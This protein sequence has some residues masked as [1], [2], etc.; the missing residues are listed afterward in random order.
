MRELLPPAFQVHGPEDLLDRSELNSH[1]E[2]EVPPGVRISTL[3]GT[4]PGEPDSLA[5]QAERQQLRLD[6]NTFLLKRAAKLRGFRFTVDSIAEELNDDNLIIAQDVMDEIQNLRNSFAQNV[7]PWTTMQHL[8]SLAAGHILQRSWEQ[9]GASSVLG[10]GGVKAD[11]E[12]MVIKWTDLAAASAEEEAA[13][14]RLV[15][16]KSQWASQ[17]V[18]AAHIHP[19]RR[20]GSSSPTSSE[21]AASHIDPI[22]QQVKADQS[23]D[24]HERALLGCIVDPAAVNKT[25]FDDVALDEKIKDTVRTAISLPL[26]YPEAFTTGILGQQS[27]QGVLLYGPPGTGKTHL[28]RALANESG[29]RMIAVTPGDINDM[30]VGQSEA[31]VKALFSLARKL[32]PSIVFIDEAES[33]LS[34]RGSSMSKSAAHQSTLTEF[35]QEMDGL[36]SAKDNTDTRVSVVAATNRPFDMDEAVLRRLPRRVLVDLPTAE[37]REAILGI[38]LKGEKLGEDVDLKQL[39]KETEA[40]SGSDLRHLCVTAAMDAIKELTPPPWKTREK[41]AAA[42]KN[43]QEDRGES[44]SSAAGGSSP[45]SKQVLRHR[46]HEDAKQQ[47]AVKRV[48]TSTAAAD[49]VSSS[50]QDTVS[51]M[52]QSPSPPGR[53]MQQRPSGLALHLAGGHH[54]SAVNHEHSLREP[55]QKDHAVSTRG[56]SGG[57][58]RATS[59]ESTKDTTSAASRGAKPTLPTRVLY[60]RHFDGAL[61]TIT[62]SSAVGTIFYIQNANVVY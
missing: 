37:N 33:L 61:K 51:M 18:Q 25:S 10:G 39:A 44:S 4:I 8:V 55:M 34:S 7:W 45:S 36:T 23:L 2:K 16:Y 42:T 56:G 29:S 54:S 5:L 50:P 52:R 14:K 6:I 20:S 11:D 12:K 15:D 60:K 22:V 47:E 38:L 35:M 32:S 17:V 9:Q 43:H 19:R 3:V 1:S 31:K 58:G 28:S 41:A 40:Y 24:Q 49:S 26:L 21:A 59:T 46:E 57:D 48:E 62:P 27:S 53:H 30:Y 13:E